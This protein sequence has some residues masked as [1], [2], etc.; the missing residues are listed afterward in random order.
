MNPN[1]IKWYSGFEPMMSE[2]SPS[3]EKLLLESTGPPPVTPNITKVLPNRRKFSGIPKN[4]DILNSLAKTQTSLKRVTGNF[5]THGS[6]DKHSLPKIDVASST[7]SI[8]ISNWSAPLLNDS[9]D[10]NNSDDETPT[11]PS[12]P[13]I[14]GRGVHHQNSSNWSSQIFSKHPDNQSSA[15][16]EMKSSQTRYATDT[17]NEFQE[18]LRMRNQSMNGMNGG[19]DMSPFAPFRLEAITEN[20]QAAS[21]NASKSQSLPPAPLTSGQQQNSM[22][23]DHVTDI[24]N[25]FRGNYS[26]AQAVD[27]S[28]QP[29]MK[30]PHPSPPPPVAPSL[31]EK[32]DDETTTPDPMMDYMEKIN[33]GF[34]KN[35][36]FDPPTTT[37]STHE[38]ETE[39]PIAVEKSSKSDRIRADGGQISSS[40]PSAQNS[41]RSRQSSSSSPSS[42]KNINHRNGNAM[43]SHSTNEKSHHHHPHPNHVSKSTQT[44]QSVRLSPAEMTHLDH[45]RSSGKGNEKPSSLVTPTKVF[46]TPNQK[47][48]QKQRLREKEKA[49]SQN[50]DSQSSNSNQDEETVTIKEVPDK[51]SSP[52]KSKNA[53]QIEFRQIQPEV[54]YHDPH[55]MSPAPIMR[56]RPRPFLPPHPFLMGAGLPKPLGAPI[57]ATYGFQYPRYYTVDDSLMTKLTSPTLISNADSNKIIESTDPNDSDE[58][59]QNGIPKQDGTF[60]VKG[61]IIA[62]VPDG[63]APG[64]F[65]FPTGPIGPLV[66]HPLMPTPYMPHPLPSIT[67]GGPPPGPVTCCKT[68]WPPAHPHT[69]HHHMPHIHPYHHNH[70]ASG[71]IIFTHPSNTNNNEIESSSSSPSSASSSGH[72]LVAKSDTGSTTIVG[73]GLVDGPPAHPGMPGDTYC[74]HEPLIPHPLHL[75]HLKLQRILFPFIWKKRLLMHHFG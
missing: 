40:P 16:T 9:S 49:T 2:S 44:T 72:H 50:Q 19:M 55:M 3:L 56:I 74:F 29:P 1:H 52:P 75:K 8:V 42:N 34:N 7:G 51:S 47:Q 17:I 38:T 70:H 67:H 62:E 63:V 26:I 27:D 13:K 4:K 59:N 22:T 30:Q 68:Y 21:S 28:P 41:M 43:S 64:P 53:Q 46:G 39:A 10:D 57:P 11:A 24:L 5:T 12:Q 58:N 45:V 15:S 48:Q 6:H 25:R 60:T 31:A 71:E 36:K 61:E 32:E 18:F 33:S 35:D 66:P 65:G 20:F 23:E 73:S 54:I 69:N 14:K 37:V